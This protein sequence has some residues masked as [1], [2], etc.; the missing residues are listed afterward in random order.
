MHVVQPAAAWHRSDVLSDHQHWFSLLRKK[1]L[2]PF[3]HF[4]LAGV[5]RSVLEY[6]LVE[7]HGCTHVTRM[8]L[9]RGEGSGGDPASVL[10]ARA[11][12]TAHFLP[13]TTSSIATHS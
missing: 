13:Q 1:R 12:R 4:V 6:A 10:V 5:P 8:L 2:S 11:G 3:P 7:L 9:L